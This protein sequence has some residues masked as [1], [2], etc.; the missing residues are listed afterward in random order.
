MRQRGRDLYKR[1]GFTKCI[2]HVNYNKISGMHY[3]SLCE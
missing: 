3:G 2:Y 1:G